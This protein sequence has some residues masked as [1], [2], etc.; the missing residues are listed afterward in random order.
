MY[1][2]G[3]F[4]VMTGIL[5][6]DMPHTV[7]PRQSE[8]DALYA[9]YFGSD[10]DTSQR[11]SYGTSGAPF[12]TDHQILEK[13]K[14]AA[15][16]RQF[17]VSFGNAVGRSPHYMVEADQHTMNEY[18]VL[19]GSSSK[20]RK[21]TSWG[22]VKRIF[23]KIDEYWRSRCIISGLTRPCSKRG[24]EGCFWMFCLLDKG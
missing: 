24:L 12:P 23:K 15:N 22:Y 18:A 2:N 3:R 6:D 1:E 7:E 10:D 11:S 17:L 8:L 9:E 14:A 16:G 19:A 20:G 21:G 13:A 5:I 4:F